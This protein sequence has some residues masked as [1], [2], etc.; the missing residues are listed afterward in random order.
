MKSLRNAGPL[1]WATL[2]GCGV[3]TVAMLLLHG[4]QPDLSP[5]DQ[6]MSYYVHGPAGWLTTLG[7]LGLGFGSLT[8]TLALAQEPP[9]T[10]SRGGNWCLGIWTL[11]VFLG[12]LFAADPPGQ[13]D[14]PPSVSGAIHGMAAMVALVVFPVAAILWSRR[15]R[16]GTRQTPFA[17]GLYVLALVCAASLAAF[18]ASLVPV[19]LRPGPPV[20]LGLTE[21]VLF[22]A[23]VA[24]IVVAALNKAAR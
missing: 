7:L 4:L 2:I 22:A 8:L 1:V 13:W 11:G 19:F 21:R 9:Q 15:L 5:L 24:W 20:L 12:A 14:R 6:A 23:D 3:F 10:F 16:Q 17:G 18:L